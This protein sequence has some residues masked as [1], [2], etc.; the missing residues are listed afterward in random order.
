VCVYARAC[1][2]ARVHVCTYNKITCTCVFVSLVGSGS[3][4]D[5]QES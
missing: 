1:A 5:I 2:P 4:F 3:N